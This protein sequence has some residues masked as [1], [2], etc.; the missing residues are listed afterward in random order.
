MSIYNYQGYYSIGNISIN[1]F[2]LLSQAKGSIP[3]IG[4]YL[5]VNYEPNIK[6][7]KYII[8]DFIEIIINKY[9][10]Y[11]VNN[12]KVFKIESNSIDEYSNIVDNQ[13]FNGQVGDDLP[14]ASSY[15]ETYFLLN[16]IDDL[17]SCLYIKISTT[18]FNVILGTFKYSYKSL[19]GSFIDKYIIYTQKD[20][21][22]SD[23][24]I[25]IVYATNLYD[26]YH[27]FYTSDS[28][29][30]EVPISTL[31]GLVK[32]KITE[33]KGGV[34]AIIGDVLLCKNNGGYFKYYTILSDSSGSK[35]LGINNLNY[36]DKLTFDGYFLFTNYGNLEILNLCNRFSKNG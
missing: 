35:S 17:T 24:P 31:Y 19:N 12:D 29:N 13:N 6:L 32:S 18:W 15:P 25:K 26:G 34:N 30:D 1:L 22:F 11:S 28:I 5:L 27:G 3:E 20:S 2:D 4:D 33:L 7:Y 16:S 8:N 10:F 36:A 21:I 9:L 23:N 14:E